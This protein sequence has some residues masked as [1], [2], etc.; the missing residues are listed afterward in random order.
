MLSLSE[1]I[2]KDNWN[3]YGV[4]AFDKEFVD[5]C[6]EIGN[7]LYLTPQVFPTANKSIQF[8]YEL[9]GSYMEIEIYIDKIVHIYKKFSCGKNSLRVLKRYSIDDLNKEL[10]LFMSEVNENR[11]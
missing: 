5:Y 6:L 3:G 2:L 11:V 4:K 1:E 7:K 8:E 9:E 10:S